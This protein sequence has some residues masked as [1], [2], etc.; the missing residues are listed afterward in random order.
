MRWL[1]AAG[2]VAVAACGSTSSE[3]AGTPTPNPKPKP[4][5]SPLA[6]T[7]PP[8]PPHVTTGAD[9]LLAVTGISATTSDVA[10]ADLQRDY[11]A[12]KLAV[13]DAVQPAADAR[14]HCHA[15]A[16][17][18]TTVAAFIPR[19]KTAV[20]VTDLDHT[21]SQLATL[22]VDGHDLFAD[23]RGYPLV[24]PGA[25][26]T[27]RFTHFIL[28]GVTAITRATGA[29]CERH[30]I[31]WLTANLRD[32][33]AGAD[34]V[35]V[36]NEVSFKPDCEYKTKDTYQFCSKPADFQALSDLHV[37][38]V[39]LTGNHN[40]DFGDQP[41]RDTYRWYY[42]HGFATFGAGLDPE[43]ANAPIILPLAG[44]KKLGIIGFNESCPLHEC[45]KQPGEVG[46]NAYD[47][48]KALADLDSIRKDY[49]ADV[50]M[51]TVQ[52]REWDNAA[53]TKS[54][55]AIAHLLVDHGADLVYGSQAH[56]LQWLEFYKGKPIYFGIG[57]F[58]FDQVHR[59]GVRQAFFVH[60]YFFDGRLVHSAPV[61]TFMASD[62]QPALATP[63]QIT[64]E[65]AIVYKD[66]LLYAAP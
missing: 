9:A 28:T 30:G 10:L 49:G 44:G 26:F 36:S 60:H 17:A 41:F 46:A 55:A 53:P 1:I 64:A 27:G 5:A 47:E 29:A 37:N 59:T 7:P 4:S 8:P 43:S 42:E 15:P 32:Q 2:V 14:F 65:K 54:Q 22:T 13:V 51:V 16:D 57:N 34:Y 58:L 18:V 20:L 61:W 19:A 25:D 23:P 56:Q 12:G 63:E 62:R 3:P 35:H 50:V 21:T 33:F 48:A 52:F 45:A 66:D 24:A 31:A 11:C 38:V 40:R 6:T 39:E